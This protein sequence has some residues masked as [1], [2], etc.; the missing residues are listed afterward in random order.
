MKNN[1]LLGIAFLCISFSSLAQA[2]YTAEQREKLMQLYEQFVEKERL[3]EERVN[4]YILKHN[5]ERKM[6]DENGN[7]IELVDVDEVTGEPVYIAADNLNAANTISTNKVWTGGSLGLGLDGQGMI[8][9]EWD[10]G[11]VRKTHV[12]FGT[13]VIQM[14]NAQTLSS[15]ATHVAGT[16]IAAGVKASAKGMAPLATLHAYNWNS[17]LSEMTLAAA[18]GLLISNHSYGQISGWRYSNSEWRWY[19]DTAISPVEDWKYGFYTTRASDWDQLSHDA[20]YYLIVKSAGNDRSG[21]HTGQHLVRVNGN[22]VPSTQYRD[23][24]GPYHC[25]GTYS[26]AKNILTMAAVN[27]IINGW[28]AP[29]DVTMSTFSSWGPT[30]DG[31]IKPDIS[32]NGVSL[33][34]TESN[35]DTAYSNKSGTSMSAPNLTGSAILLQQY[36]KQ[37]YDKFMKAAT[38][39]ALLI[40]TA[41]EA[42]PHDGPDYMF[43]WGLANIEKA[44]QLIANTTSN[45]IIETEIANRDSMILQFIT[46]TSGPFRATISW[47]DLPGTPKPNSL[48]PPDLMLVN[49]LDIRLINVLNPSQ[50]F[51]PYILD[52]ANPSAAATTGD[53]FRDNV[54]QIYISNLPPGNYKLK[55]THKGSLSAKQDF[56]LI[57]SGKMIQ[58]EAAFAANITGICPGNQIQFNDVSPMAVTGRTWS[59]PGGNPATSTDVNPTIVYNTPGFYAVTLTVQ[60]SMG[61]LVKMEP[62][63]IEVFQPADASV[64]V[65]SPYCLPRTDTVSITPTTAGGILTGSI[66]DTVNNSINFI[67]QHIGVGSYPIY[68][69]IIDNNQCESFDTAYVVID[70]L[71]VLVGN[72]P[73][74]ICFDGGIINLNYYTPVNGIYSGPGVTNNQIDPWQAGIGYQ[75]LNYE[76]TKASG[77]SASTSFLLNI[78]TCVGVEETIDND[79]TITLFPNPVNEQLFVHFSKHQNTYKKFEIINVSGQKIQEELISPT[80]QIQ[81]NTSMLASGFY[82]FKLLGEQEER[83][84]KFVK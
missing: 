6:F 55:I 72:V 37:I 2:V 74:R 38:L 64:P 58:N 23:P 60:T 76:Y 77:C 31:R 17:D 68:H 62:S 34:S 21:N 81:L 69:Y 5:V 11:A 20:P 79:I 26:N 33:H 32:A 42:G 47:T 45:K 28:S 49:D 84:L 14:D 4:A 27:D 40:H 57:I 59:F 82:L 65:N 41:D 1:I 3:M 13:R 10:E 80:S 39:K 83:V 70:S 43:G 63:Y 54:E 24:N 51:M 25:A 12:E 9:G 35:A 73:S 48:N 46:D 19:G 52:P 66:V 7:V 44:A 8:V 71:P 29:G 22:W 16:L 18:N 50:V 78:E 56:S 30:D 61:T 36:H 75:V 67:P 53:N 15:H